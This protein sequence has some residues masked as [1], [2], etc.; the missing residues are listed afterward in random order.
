[1]KRL[2]FEGE[3]DPTFNLKANRFLRIMH[4]D[5]EFMLVLPVARHKEPCSKQAAISSRDFTSVSVTPASVMPPFE[6]SRI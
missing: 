6:V 1:M 3:V 2:V 4:L 5:W